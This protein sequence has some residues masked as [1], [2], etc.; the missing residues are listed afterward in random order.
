MKAAIRWM[1]ENHVAANLLMLFFLVGGIVVSMQIKQEVFPDVALDFIRIQVAY[2]GAGPEEVEEGIILKIEE[3]LTGIE[4]IKDLRSTGS[5]GFA[6]VMAELYPGVDQ[7]VVLQ[8][9][10]SEIDRIV[11]FPGESEKPVVSKVMRKREVLTLAV[12]KAQYLA[13]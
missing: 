12:S 9:I 4:G 7:D 8:E 11:T 3:N 1:A 5:E 2:P 13:P 10:K 6:S